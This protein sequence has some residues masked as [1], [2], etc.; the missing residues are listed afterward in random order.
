MI[1]Q[2]SKLVENAKARYRKK[3]GAALEY[4]ATGIKTYWAIM[5]SVLMKARVP[6]IPPLLENDRFILDF[7]AKADIFSDHFIKQ[8]NTI[9]TGSQIP[10]HILA[11]APPLTD[12][13]FSNEKILNIIRSLNSNNVHC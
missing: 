2:S 3:V 9:D 8:C 10:Q 11:I 6:N 13:P 12:F 1:S 5:K 7:T 4:P